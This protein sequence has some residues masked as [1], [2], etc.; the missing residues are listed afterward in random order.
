MVAKFLDH[1][2]RELK[3]KK[4]ITKQEN[5]K[6]V[7]ALYQQ[8]NNTARASC[9]LVRFLAVVTTLPNLT[10]PP[11]EVGEHNAKIFFFFF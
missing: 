3:R 5:W 1:N 4:P 10:N 8:N 11:Y 2:N 6:K 9:F 7:I